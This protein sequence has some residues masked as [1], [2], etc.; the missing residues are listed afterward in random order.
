M[1]HLRVDDKSSVIPEDRLKNDENRHQGG[2]DGAT[3]ELYYGGNYLSWSRNDPLSTHRPTL[4]AVSNQVE[5]PSCSSSDSMCSLPQLGK[6]TLVN[7]KPHSVYQQPTQTSYNPSNVTFPSSIVQEPT[8]Q[9]L[10]NPATMVPRPTKP[11][12]P[13]LIHQADNTALLSAATSLESVTSELFTRPVTRKTAKV[14]EPS[15][16]SC[17]TTSISSSYLS[18][19]TVTHEV[20]VQ[21]TA[22]ESISTQTDMTHFEPASSDPLPSTSL[23]IPSST[24]VTHEVSVQVTGLENV[25][26]QT[27]DPENHPHTTHCLPHLSHNL[28]QL[29]STENDLEATLSTGLKAPTKHSSPIM[30]SPS[31]NPATSPTKNSSTA[32]SGGDRSSVTLGDSLWRRQSSSSVIVP[33]VKDEDISLLLNQGCHGV[34]ALTVVHEARVQDSLPSETDDEELLEELFFVSTNER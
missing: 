24:T 23:S 1:N 14:V 30:N 2:S 28:A 5:Q 16:E 18:S 32:S 7:T 21:V 10:P 20:S 29:Q 11:T 6:E 13:F 15:S 3:R 26:T 31:R 22:L 8:T 12:P 4:Q 9:L 34:D 27:D 19:P 25:S 33:E 17:T